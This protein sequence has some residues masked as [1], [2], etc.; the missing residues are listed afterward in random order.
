MTSKN[1][2]F[3]FTL[4]FLSVFFNYFTYDEAWF[5]YVSDNY[6]YNKNLLSFHNERFSNPIYAVLLSKINFIRDINFFFINRFFSLLAIIF[7]FYLINF[8]LN[9]KFNLFKNYFIF[10][11][12]LFAFWFSFHG[13]GMSARV[14][15]II[16]FCI[17]FFLFS[18][19]KFKE[20]IFFFIVSTILNFLLILQHPNIIPLIFLNIL[21]FIFFFKKKIFNLPIF[22]LMIVLIFYF[23]KY[24]FFQIIDSYNEPVAIY[25]NGSITTLLDFNLYFESIKKD[26]VFQARFRHLYNFYPITFYILILNYFLVFIHL[27]WVKDF[28]NQYFNFFTFLFFLWNIFFLLSPTKLSHHF[29][30]IFALLS[31][32]LPFLLFSLVEKIKLLLNIKTS[33][34]IFKYFSLMLILLISLKSLNYFHNN[35]F[36]YKF[37]GK[38]FEVNNYIFFNKLFKN[39]IIIQS[40]NDKMTNK[41]FYGNPEFKYVFNKANYLGNNSKKI[42][43]DVEFFVVLSRMEKCDD[44]EKLFNSKYILKTSFYMNDEIFIVCEKSNEQQN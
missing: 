22:F 35:Y 18:I 20:N 38:Y 43:E 23:A 28:K 6:F 2:I 33:S 40:V 24:H 10:S 13:G 11:Y 3:Y 1:F 32:M 36:L 9:K 15:S 26:V 14:D 31:L 8:I 19:I 42:K 17:V 12:F 39:E 7:L 21:I 25:T 4:I 5:Y 27:I 30:I 44:Y 41:N 34:N 16:S 29:A 37:L